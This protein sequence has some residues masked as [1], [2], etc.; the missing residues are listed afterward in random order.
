MFLSRKKEYPAGERRC[1]ASSASP[2]WTR[3]AAE[4]AGA[5]SR[6]CRVSFT[7]GKR[8]GINPDEGFPKWRESTDAKDQEEVTRLLKEKYPQVTQIEFL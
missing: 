2:G 4:E 6:R 7:D 5:R 1:C 8:R 3:P